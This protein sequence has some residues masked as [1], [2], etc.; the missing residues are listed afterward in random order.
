MSLYKVIE[1]KT[2][3]LLMDQEM[4]YMVEG[5]RKTLRSINMSVPVHCIVS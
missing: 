5:A 1:S 2:L 3:K 4:T